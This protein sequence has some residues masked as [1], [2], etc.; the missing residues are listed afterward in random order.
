MNKAAWLLKSVTLLAFMLHLLPAQA[1]PAAE[2]PLAVFAAHPDFTEVRL[3]PTGDYVAAI[4]RKD[5]RSQLVVLRTATLE[6]SLRLQLQVNQHVDDIWWASPRR[7][8]ISGALQ[9]DGWSAPRRTGELFAVDADGKNQIYLSGERDGQID[10]A[11]GWMI[12]PIADDDHNVLMLLERYGA[13]D[14]GEA[15][16][17]H[18]LNIDTGSRVRVA[19]APIKGQATFAADA[20]GRVLN[21]GVLDAL[22]QHHLYARQDEQAAWVELPMPPDMR[23][24][25]E[26]ILPDGSV[27]YTETSTREPIKNCIVRRAAGTLQGGEVLGCSHGKPTVLYSFDRREPI[28]LRLYD[29]ERPRLMHL[30][31]EHP[32]HLLLQALERD[33][34]SDAVLYLVYTS[35]GSKAIIKVISDRDPG[36]YYLFDRA[37]NQVRYLFSQ[38]DEIDPAVMSPRQILKLPAAAQSDAAFL[39]LPASGANKPPL[40]VKLRGVYGAS[41]S[42]TW[43]ADSQALASRGYAVL[44]IDNYDGAARRTSAQVVQ[45]DPAIGLAAALIE[46][47]KWL[48]TQDQID[49]DRICIHGDSYGAYIALTAAVQEPALFRCIVSEAGI[50]D[51]DAWRKDTY[52]SETAYGRSLIGL[53]MSGIG[54]A[55]SSPLSAIGKLEAPLLLIHGRLDSIVPYGQAKQLMKALERESV[56]YE[57]Y[58]ESNEAHG[59][60]LQAHRTKRYEELLAFF[61]RHIGRRSAGP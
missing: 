54:S 48:R 29:S 16:S 49:G 12:D 19:T 2:I 57:K 52:L 59:F 3:S 14:R 9:T 24:G 18:K 31:S 37:K 43:D 20:S 42:W 4:L 38:R 41:A 6:A 1:A 39:T 22:G 40:V 33:L 35:D 47:L 50:V 10:H 11:F 28:A 21:V 61:D 44:D 56:S 55:M 8:V 30:D 51:I 60:Y 53:Y 36:R 13:R 26:R 23:V 5:E 34:A 25:I 32:D 7:L 17:A 45:P 58:I 46:N 15:M 27:L